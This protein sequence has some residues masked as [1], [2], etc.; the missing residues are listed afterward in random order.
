M[1]TITSDLWGTI[2][3]AIPLTPCVIRASPTFYVILS[4][5]RAWPPPTVSGLWT[6]GQ[7]GFWTITHPEGPSRARAAVAAGRVGWSSD[8]APK[9]PCRRGPAVGA[10]LSRDRGRVE[11]VS[12]RKTKGGSPP[13]GIAGEA[14]G[15]GGKGEGRVPLLG[16]SVAR[17][18]G[19]FFG[20]SA[21]AA[22]RHLRPRGSPYGERSPGEPT[23]G[24]RRAA[25][26][27]H[28]TRRTRDR[29]SRVDA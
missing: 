10:L 12:S 15:Q 4:R 21:G 29:A 14:I 2:R 9:A 13:Q 3:K 23:S 17:P 26:P 7:R 8:R 25:N 27:S 20:R 11:R 6:S 16:R 24:N 28:G 22:T 19:R 5:S 1:K 18:R